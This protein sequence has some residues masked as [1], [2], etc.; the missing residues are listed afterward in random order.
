MTV[1]IIII[2]IIIIIKDFTLLLPFSAN[3]DP[4]SG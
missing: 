4:I 3:V 2:I 1:F